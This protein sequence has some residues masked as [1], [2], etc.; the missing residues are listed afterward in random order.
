MV[1]LFL[2]IA[3]V[4]GLLP[5]GT[6]AEES[7]AADVPAG[8]K[9]VSITMNE[10]SQ[11][12]SLIDPNDTPVDVGTPDSGYTYTLSLE[13][14]DYTL[15]GYGSDG[16]TINGTLNFTV[17][18][19]AAQSFQ[20][21]TVTN[22]RA[23]N[24]GWVW[25][26]DY[27]AELA[28]KSSDGTARTAAFGDSGSYKSFLCLDGDTASV[29]FRPGESHSGD[30]AEKTMTG[31]QT[32][33]KS[34]GFSTAL[35]QVCA[36]TVTA[37]K[38][39]T[40]RAGTLS[41]YFVYFYL[42][43]ASVDTSAADTDTY[44]YQ[45]GKGTTCFYKVSG[46]GGVT[47]WNWITPTAATDCTVTEA[48]LYLDSDSRNP[49]TVVADLSDNSYDVADLYLTV[50]PQG[51]LTM[52]K[53]GSR[54]LDC[55]R[56]W[57]AIEGISN[58]KTAEPDFHYTVLNMD[59]QPDDNVLTVTPDAENSAVATLEAKEDGTAIVLVT[60]D[61]MSNMSGMGGT[62]FSAVWPENT[63]VFVVTVGEN[64]SGIETGMLLNAGKN[65][66]DN[67]L[68]GD[69]IDAELDVLYYRSDTDGASYTFTP[70][71]GA[72]ISVARPSYQDGAMT[73][74]GFSDTGVTANG[75]GSVTVSGLPE[76]R[77]IL[78]VTKDGKRAYQVITAKAVSMNCTY[79]NALGQAI[80]ADQLQAGDTI[81]IKFDR[82]YAPANK[83]AGVYNMA[84][85]V[86]LTDGDG[87]QYKST[88]N[89][90]QFAG[91]DAAQTVSV[92][93]PKYDTDDTFTL[94]GLLLE[95][96]FGSPYGNH[97]S[98]THA[99]G[100][101]L[102][103][104]AAS[105]TGY[106]G[107]LPELT[108]PL[109][110]SGYSWAKFEL[111]DEDTGSTVTGATVTVEDS[112]GNR[113][114]PE[115][116]GRYAVTAG[117]TY[118]VT[119][120]ADG[121]YY[122]QK[123]VTIPTDI[124]EL[125]YRL[126]L[127]PAADSGSWNGQDGTEADGAEPKKDKSGAYQ[128][129]NAEELAWFAAAVNA[130]AANTTSAVLTTDIDLAGYPWTPIG[131]SSKPYSGTFDGGY[132][133][134]RN[135]Y[136]KNASCAGLFGVN[137]G[138]IQNLTVQGTIES[139][140][141]TAGGVVGEQQAGT[142]QS[143]VADVDLAYTGAAA[144][145]N[146]DYGGVVGC[147]G[148]L[149]AGR[150][151]I[152][153]CA[154]LGN[155]E[156]GDNGGTAGG[157]VGAIKS[158][159]VLVQNCYVRGNVTGQK[160]VGGVAGAGNGTSAQPGII[161]NCYVA[162][163]VT[164]GDGTSTGAVLGTN[165]AASISDQYITV[166]NTYYLSGCCARACG[167]GTDLTYVTSGVVD[168]VFKTAD[169]LKD[170][171]VLTLL[172]PAF[173]ADTASVNDG[174]PVLIWQT[175]RAVT[176]A[177]YDYTAMDAGLTGA[178]PAG[179][180]MERTVRLDADDTA[181]NAVN[182]AFSAAGISI[183]GLDSGYVSQIGVLGG[184]ADYPYAGW[185]LN[186]NNDDFTN[187][188]LNTL[189]LKDGDCLAFHYTL[190]GNDINAGWYGL[191]T[192]S[193]FT[194]A[195]QTVQFS[196]ET[197]Y[198]ENYN[199]E[200][201]YYTITD[202]SKTELTGSGTEE[203][204]FLISVCVPSSTNL[205]SQ[206][207]AWT[208]DFNSHYGTVSSLDGAKDY[209]NGV[210]FTVS[211]SGGTYTAYYK[212]EVTKKSS[213]GGGTS[214]G[215]SI[216]VTFRL[217]GSTKSSGDVDLS[218]GGW[219]GSEYVT[220]IKTS[221]Y[222]MDN[223]DTVADLFQEAL[224][225]MDLTAIGLEDNY[226]STIYAPD[227][228]DGYALNEFTNGPWSGWMYTVNGAHPN[229][230]LSNY[231][232]SDGDMVVFHYVDDCRYEV[233][234]YKNGT[235]GDS[236][237]WSKWLDAADINPSSEGENSGGESSSE[238]NA[239]S[240]ATDGTAQP[241]KTGQSVFSDVSG[242]AWYAEAVSYVTEQGLMSGAGDGQFCPNADMTR[243][244]LVTVLYR[245]T[246]TPKASITDGFSDEGEGQWYTDAVLWAGQND[247]VGGYGDGSFGVGDSVTREQIAVILYRF[248]AYLGR[249]TGGS[250]V[251]LSG[252]DDAGQISDW[253][254]SAVRWANAAGLLK[255]TG[256]TTLSPCGIASRGEV[257]EILMRFC[258][259]MLN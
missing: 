202:N 95:T 195:G 179:V 33:N 234:D 142:I 5:V 208:T 232:L 167:T 229:V 253:A 137:K 114:Q 257:A 164:G 141:N 11:T 219:K 190:D 83:L 47:D 149:A 21:W 181:A 188:G 205:L 38:D 30:Y 44:T 93:I 146:L 211:S 216:R 162:G 230:G 79:T 3:L 104:T 46:T 218:D 256:E 112:A 254:L 187:W 9:T 206:T 54:T 236:S 135:L 201:R 224:D 184:Q 6:L 20:V 48:D 154:A 63:G 182:A 227:A 192:L 15:T 222:S 110:D 231:I 213:T 173:A 76:G 244:M 23:T 170:T 158:A 131:T 109:K 50:N 27:T 171:A 175:Q 196:K 243:A 107:S 66:T 31:T 82:L 239:D 169:E 134:V 116:D 125:T 212:V 153:D 74:S 14:G 209:T 214:S 60:Y 242:D 35:Q 81:T 207:A 166:S 99:S 78:R 185:C 17:T 57:Q 4:S 71:T 143:C 115:A 145:D 28:V 51:W 228:L 67:K 252:Y 61:A 10:V 16:T 77:S 80:S 198:D 235:L 225:R 157:V 121:Y 249:D 152:A 139:D 258:K 19:A 123:T 7:G 117:E 241:G 58:A 150:T 204:P 189:N 255:G 94:T 55:F 176:V 39:G 12:I 245:A 75:D 36:V 120:Y 34:N 70:E 65:T 43:P 203:D 102:Q 88:A 105:R 111:T 247:I 87:N 159:N 151:V 73:F 91:T 42:D 13:P 25:G 84:T 100:R 8:T 160:K 223:G 26:T 122:L 62:F 138:I 45:M 161:Q 217:V 85:A 237:T 127:T 40:V 24:S 130:G 22:V 221:S 103:F 132:H 32:A 69:A 96:G 193:S 1:S 129:S 133:A 186:Y 68:A 259:T 72:S 163:T 140:Q 113:T 165:V 147:A 246:G 108:F 119:V 126:A 49:N 178:S 53:G 97:R 144:N 92:T 90:Y 215:D 136:V 168:A 52:E 197:T 59:G 250:A 200:T 240:T 226:I 148:G 248:M 251:D 210:T 238:K 29:T 86:C 199:A 194:L 89:Q 18:D 128:I 183:T 191:P 2:A 233:E 101:S 156:I 124:S 180:V 118:T 177:A 220:W 174:Y 172:G 37:P 41:S 106:L 56:N 98:V 64:G 155:V